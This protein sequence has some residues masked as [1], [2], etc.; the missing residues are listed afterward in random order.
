M[1]KLIILFAVTLFSCKKTNPTPQKA[2]TSNPTT[3]NTIIPKDVVFNFDPSTIGYLYINWN[4]HYNSQID[5]LYSTSTSMLINRSIS[6]DTIRFRFFSTMCYN[7]SLNPSSLSITINGV[8]KK[9]YSNDNGTDYR[10]V[11]LN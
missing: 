11:V 2:I 5:S 3:V 8:L 1:K 10:Y 4:Y 6:S 7:C 9:S